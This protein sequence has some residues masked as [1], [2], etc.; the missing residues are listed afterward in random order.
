[1][2]DFDQMTVGIADVATDLV[3]VL[4]R[5]RHEL[6]TTGAWSAAI[7]RNVRRRA[8]IPTTGVAGPI[9][10]ERERAGA[11]TEGIEYQSRRLPAGRPVVVVKLL[12]AGVGVERRGR[13]IRNVDSIN[14]GR[15]VLGGSGTEHAKAEGQAVC[16]FQAAGVGGVAA[17]QGEQGCPGVDGQAL[18]EFEADLKGNL[19]KI[20]NRMPTVA[21][22]VAQTVVAMRL[23]ERAE[24]RFHPDS[25]G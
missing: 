24:P 6:S 20:C 7:A 15:V 3:L 16:N 2:P 22:R 8:S 10:R 23:G 19:Y 1:L 25:Y 4:L 5:R 13:L 11:E 12:L 14:R 21:D 17:G 18:E 9:G